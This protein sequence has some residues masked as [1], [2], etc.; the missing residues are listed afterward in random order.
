VHNQSSH[1]AYLGIAPQVIQLGLKPGGQADVVGIHPGY[2][3]GSGQLQP[4]IES[5]HD[6]GLLQS[7]NPKPGFGQSIGMQDAA[8]GIR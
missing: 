4:V 5:G 1:Q 7:E 6:P 8:G 3:F 2:T